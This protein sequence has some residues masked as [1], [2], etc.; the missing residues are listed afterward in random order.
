MMLADCRPPQ[1][2]WI[3]LRLHSISENVSPEGVG[4]IKEIKHPQEHQPLS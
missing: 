1:W 4:Q 3:T 2:A